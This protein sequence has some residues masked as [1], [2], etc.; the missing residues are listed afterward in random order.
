MEALR[1]IH[2]ARNPSGG[3]QHRSDDDRGG[4]QTVEL[5]HPHRRNGRVLRNG[6]GHDG[7][8]VEQLRK[9]RFEELHRRLGLRACSGADSLAAKK[10]IPDGIRRLPYGTVHGPGGDVVLSVNQSH[11]GG[12]RAGHC[13]P[14]FRFIYKE[15]AKQKCDASGQALL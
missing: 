13:D 14:P 12:A 4:P 8:H 1:C 15:S 2:A 10:R 7:F 5:L 9:R 11:C 3:S 6:C